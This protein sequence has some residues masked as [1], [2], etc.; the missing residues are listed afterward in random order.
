MQANL[1][2]H[3]FSTSIGPFP[4]GKSEKEKKKLQKFEYL[5]NIKSFLDEIKTFF[6]AFEG[7]SFDEKT[8][9]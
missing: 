8:K 2:H 4:S 9:I 1:W 6:I 3:K 5:K 7:L